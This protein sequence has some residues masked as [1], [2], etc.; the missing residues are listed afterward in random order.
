MRWQVEVD[1]DLNAYANAR[2]HFDSRKMHASKEAKTA[3][4]NEKAMAA[5]EKK[6]AAQLR[7][8]L[9]WWLAFWQLV[10]VFRDPQRQLQPASRCANASAGQSRWRNLQ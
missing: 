9:S 7:Q 2:L 6:A 3:A 4:A 8:V 10:S 5:A 1:L